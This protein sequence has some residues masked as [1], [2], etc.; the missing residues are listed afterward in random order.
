MAQVTVA[1]DVLVWA[2]QTSGKPV[3]AFA[4]KFAGWNA[5]LAEQRHPTLKQI[6]ALSRF[7]GIPFGY[8]FL[9]APPLLRLPIPDFRAGYA[10][11]QGGP[12]Q[13]LLEVVHTC[14]RRQGWYRDYAT[15]H[16]LD[17]L[18]FVGSADAD[19]PTE[20]AAAEIRQHLLFDVVQRGALKNWSEARRHLLRAFEL[21]GGLTVA[22][23]MVGN[24]THR[25]LDLDEFR[26]FTL[27][28]D[29]APLICVNTRDTVNGQIFT[30]AHEIAH[31]WRGATGVSSEQVEIE[32]GSE[33]EGWCNRVASEV[34]VPAADLRSRFREP[35]HGDWRAELERLAKVCRCGTLVILLRLKQVGLIGAAHS[36]D[37]YGHELAHLSALPDDEPTSGGGNFYLSQPYRIGER[38]SRA[39]IADTLEGRTSLSEA[40]SLMSLGSLSTFDAYAQE[41]GVA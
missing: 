17:G 26:G 7:T 25:L 22:T 5:W 38:L 33:I 29:V 19:T 39:L 13:D 37:L 24:N 18:P 10:R 12:S 8:F 40:L 4:E 2:Q 21:L 15:F 31:V 3:E 1:H 23:S 14:Q 32:P 27:A 11:G 30:I 41:L 20:V 9:P 34:L 6:E 35:T 16:G 36:D 28:D